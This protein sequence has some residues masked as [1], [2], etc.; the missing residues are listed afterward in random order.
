MRRRDLLKA[1]AAAPL[2]R[3]AVGLGAALGAASATSARG[4]YSRAR[5]GTAAWPAVADWERLGRDTGGR[6]LTLESPFAGCGVAARDAA[7]R[8][9]LA[10]LNN[11]FF[12]GD[13]PALTQTSGWVDAWTS[14]PSVYAVAAESTADVVAAVNFAREHRLRL[15]VKGCGHSYLGASNSADSLLIWTRRMNREIGRAHV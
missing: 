12:V 13:Q 2:V 14:R 3:T 4:A 5:P 10:R 11:P 1:A 8:D 7:C 9:M 6:L 15:V